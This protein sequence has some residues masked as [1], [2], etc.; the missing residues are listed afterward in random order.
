MPVFRTMLKIIITIITAPVIILY[1]IK[2]MLSRCRRFKYLKSI[3]ELKKELRLKKEQ[4]RILDARF[5]RVDPEIKEEILSQEKEQ[6]GLDRIL[7][8]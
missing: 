3:Q 7:K 6:L 1:R 2:L 8:K 5:E 4:N